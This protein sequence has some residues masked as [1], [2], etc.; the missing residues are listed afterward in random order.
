MGG[1]KTFASFKKGDVL[2]NS[3][4]L[5]LLFLKELGTL[6]R[7]SKMLGSTM[8]TVQGR[9]TVTIMG[10]LAK[11]ATE[12][13]RFSCLLGMAKQLTLEAVHRIRNIRTDRQ[14]VE[15]NIK[16]LREGR[17]REGEDEGSSRLKNTTTAALHVLDGHNTLLHVQQ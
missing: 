14:P 4:L 1:L 11:F 6:T 10:I 17:P 13:L 7:L 5:N 16:L 3:E 2:I 12:G 9:G 8:Y 15:G